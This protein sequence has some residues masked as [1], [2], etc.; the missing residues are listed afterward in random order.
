MWI[1]DAILHAMSLI[2]VK[3]DATSA[4]LCAMFGMTQGAILLWWAMLH[5][6]LHHMSAFKMSV[7]L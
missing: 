5:A 4:M 1:H 6:M 3:L 2:K 7:R